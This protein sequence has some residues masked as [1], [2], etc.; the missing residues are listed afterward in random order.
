[1]ITYFIACLFYYISN[2]HNSDIDLANGNTFV[3]AH[4]I[5]Y[6]E[7]KIVSMAY[8]ALTTLSTVGYGDL[9]PVSQL[10][11]IITVIVM[12]G[13]VAFFSYIMGNFIEII[14]NYEQKLGLG[15]KSDDL[16]YFLISMQR[17][18][19]NTPITRQMME[20][21]YLHQQ[22]FWANDR[23]GTLSSNEDFKQIPTYIIETVITQH[24][25]YDIFQ[26]F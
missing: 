2:E 8:F 12:L 7:H 19:N 23:I 6:K 5:V 24:L 1:M 9:Y 25:F 15:D 20:T 26:T 11:R 14:A 18:T 3:A 16:E 22:Y 13:G 4:G 21:V 17:F 10:E